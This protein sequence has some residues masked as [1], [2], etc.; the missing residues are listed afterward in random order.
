MN[1]KNVHSSMAATFLISSIAFAACPGPIPVCPPN[2]PL[3][4]EPGAYT[5]PCC[6]Q[7][8]ACSLNGTKWAREIRQTNPTS[9]YMTP[10]GDKVYCYRESELLIW[11]S[12][13][14]CCGDPWPE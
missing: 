14:S 9:S 10:L 13:Q 2:V 4:A 8:Q 3:M 11:I 5:W 7:E 6:Q 12:D 1:R